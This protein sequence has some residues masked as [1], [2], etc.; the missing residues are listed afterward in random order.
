[1]ILI[2]P[3]YL[4]AI[5]Q[6][7]GCNEISLVERTALI[8]LDTSYPWLYNSID[9]FQSSTKSCSELNLNC[10]D[11]LCSTCECQPYE[12]F[13][14]QTA[15]CKST[16][17]TVDIGNGRQCFIP[18][19]AVAEIP[20][21]KKGNSITKSLKLQPS[22]YQQTGMG[23]SNVN[24]FVDSLY[25]LN[26]YGKYTKQMSFDETKKYFSIQNE[27]IGDKL[28]QWNVS[29]ILIDQLQG[30][31]M[32]LKLKCFGLN[33]E[34]IESC[35]LFK[36]EGYFIPSAT[37]TTTSTTITVVTLP[38][39]TTTTEKYT[40]SSDSPLVTTTTTTTTTN[41]TVQT[42][43]QT[44]E[45]N[46]TGIIIGC[47]IA[48]ILVLAL[49]TVLIFFVRNRR[50]KDKIRHT[51]LDET[52]MRTESGASKK[53]DHIYAT[54]KPLNKEDS[55]YQTL[56]FNTNAPAYEYVPVKEKNP[57]NEGDNIYYAGTESDS[58]GNVE[59]IRNPL[60]GQPSIEE[61]DVPV[62][63][64]N[65]STENPIYQ[66]GEIYAECSET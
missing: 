46:N 35:F 38:V 57:G 44:S 1:M 2:I 15:V 23:T 27:F 54:S 19:G 26:V 41:A 62:D 51:F 6:L 64:K 13:V 34:Y 8:A 48:V 21:V 33:D 55:E 4:S 40:K 37:T 25:K 24:C 20:M 52:A 47:V 11:S 3:L 63:P 29:D 28:L 31:V 60:Y 58:T 50:R 36:V 14:S 49:I 65:I 5:L 43:N 45:T 16:K 56:N 30:N 18:T 17:D 12:T 66:E 9:T 61:S 22:S 7:T 59:D 39:D 32:K 10:A 42:G 53:D